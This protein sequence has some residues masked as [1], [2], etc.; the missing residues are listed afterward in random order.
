MK[1]LLKRTEKTRG[2]SRIIDKVA[3][4][5]KTKPGKT[6]V[7][8]LAAAF[9]TCLIRVNSYT[10]SVNSGLADN[11]IRLHVVANSDSPHD[12]ELK[13]EVR[14]AVLSYM[15]KEIKN[16]KDIEQT[17]ALVRDSL[18]EIAYVAES[19]I[20]EQGYRYEVKTMLGSH[21]FPT[22]VYGDINLP[23]GNYQALRVV[24]GKGAGSNWW[25]V[26]FPPLCFVDVT[27]GTVPDSV[28]E[29]L[30][31]VLTQEEYDIV[32]ASDGESDIPIKIKFKIVEIFQESK[33]KLAGAID[34]LFKTQG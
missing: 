27:H 18:N 24:I 16:S 22:K 10:E 23:A 4:G 3:E 5:I 21:P 31:M 12:Q 11:L 33:T 14:D 30:K 2:I 15:H 17:R 7:I 29:D 13:R 1:E 28:K 26:L 34:K 25:C 8:V 19:T 32:T 20:R 9:L 6:V